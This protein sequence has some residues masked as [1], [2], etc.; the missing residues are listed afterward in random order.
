MDLNLFGLEPRHPGRGIPVHGLGLGARP[1]LAAV[2]PEVDE[3]IQRL[4]RRMG[5]V[6]DLILGI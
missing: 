1:D 2:G 3:T 4:H 5:K 6:G